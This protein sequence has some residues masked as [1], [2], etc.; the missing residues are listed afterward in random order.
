MA[1]IWVFYLGRIVVEERM[2]SPPGTVKGGFVVPVGPIYGYLNH[3]IQ[4]EKYF[5]ELKKN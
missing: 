5:I 2:L 1:R 4:P 3:P